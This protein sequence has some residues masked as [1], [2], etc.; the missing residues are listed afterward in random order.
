LAL[1][2][3][4]SVNN[5]VATSTSS[6]SVQINLNSSF[7]PVTSQDERLSLLSVMHMQ[8][9]ESDVAFCGS[10]TEENSERMGRNE[11]LNRITK[12]IFASIPPDMIVTQN[13]NPGEFCGSCVPGL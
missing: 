12:P 2:N 8:G 9:G 10:C 13:R 11:A 4:A 3:Q 1:A 6:S 7:L 5:S